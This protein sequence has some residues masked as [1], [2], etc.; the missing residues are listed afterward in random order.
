M[1]IGFHDSTRKLMQSK[2]DTLINYVRLHTRF[3]LQK[4]GYAN[5]FNV[6]MQDHIRITCTIANVKGNILFI[7]IIPLLC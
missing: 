5:I 3:L 1:M 6:Q 4:K 7:S 2:F